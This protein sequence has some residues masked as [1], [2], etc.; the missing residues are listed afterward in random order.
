MCLSLHNLR[1]G[2]VVERILV[3][4]QSILTSKVKEKERQRERERSL[5]IGDVEGRRPGVGDPKPGGE[6]FPIF[7]SDFQ[8]FRHRRCVRER[9]REREREGKKK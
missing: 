9:E 3:I 5:D 6:I 8:N 4:K 2:G 1:G 7:S